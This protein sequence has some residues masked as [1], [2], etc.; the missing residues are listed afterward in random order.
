MIGYIRCVRSRLAG[1]GVR[2]KMARLLGG[3]RKMAKH[4]IKKLRKTF[5]K[6]KKKKK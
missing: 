5:K 2:I 4:M 6:T 3:R 1:S